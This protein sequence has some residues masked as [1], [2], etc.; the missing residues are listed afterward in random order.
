MITFLPS[1]QEQCSYVGIE[2]LMHGIPY[3]SE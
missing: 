1:C 2:M 3:N